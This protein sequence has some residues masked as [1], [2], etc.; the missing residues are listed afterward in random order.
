MK[1]LRVP[2][3]DFLKLFRNG[4][5]FRTSHLGKDLTVA[6]ALDKLHWNVEI[7]QTRECLTRHRARNHIAPDHYLVYLGLTNIWQNSLKRREVRM[8]IIDGGDPHNRLPL[9]RA[10]YYLPNENKIRYG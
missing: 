2:A 4:S 9:Y 3:H 1:L 6:V 7:E 5:C 10:K 8:N